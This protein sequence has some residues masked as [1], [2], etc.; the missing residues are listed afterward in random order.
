VG[1][2]FIEY[3]GIGLTNAKKK[4]EKITARAALPIYDHFVD[5]K[6]DPIA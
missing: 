1:G 5:T 2:E 4:E 3:Q 6:A